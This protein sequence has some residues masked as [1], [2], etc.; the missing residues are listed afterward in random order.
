MP[1][2]ERYLTP[3]SSERDW[4]SFAAGERIRKQCR[5]NVRGFSLEKQD[6]DWVAYAPPGFQHAQIASHRHMCTH[7][8]ALGSHFG[9]RA[10]RLPVSR[11]YD[12]VRTTRIA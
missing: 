10:T 4:S 3:R 7:A 8:Q 1:C 12:D 5:S 9:E 6:P 2:C 11:T